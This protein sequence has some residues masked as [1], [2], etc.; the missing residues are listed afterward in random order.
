ATSVVLPG[1][2]AAPAGV[3]ASLA[4]HPR[5]FDIWIAVPSNIA[6]TGAVSPR[7]VIAPTQ[8]LTRAGRLFWRCSAKASEVSIGAGK[9]GGFFK[10]IR[11]SRGSTTSACRGATAGTAR[12]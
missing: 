2:P 1:G 10:A 12:Q 11:R 3:L 8:A 9:G 4:A 7:N 6:T 5:P